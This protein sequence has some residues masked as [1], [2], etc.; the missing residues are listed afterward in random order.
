MTKEEVITYLKTELQFD[1][2]SIGLLDLYV[3]ELLMFNKQYN[4]ISKSTEIIV[5]DRQ[6]TPALHHVHSVRVFL[7]I[8]PRVF[9]EFQYM[10][11]VTKQF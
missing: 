10:F 7:Y 2:K 11:L 1:V 3:D 8:I 5:W 9:F 6:P 4:L